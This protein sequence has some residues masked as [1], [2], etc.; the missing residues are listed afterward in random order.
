MSKEHVEKIRT[1]GETPFEKY[2]DRRKAGKVADQATADAAVGQLAMPPMDPT[3]GAKPVPL[4]PKAATSLSGLPPITGPALEAQQA[5]RSADIAQSKSQVDVAELQ[6][7]LAKVTKGELTSE[8]LVTRLAA[9]YGKLPTGEELAV[10][11]GDITGKTTAAATPG[12]LAYKQTEARKI[13]DAQVDKSK[14]TDPSDLAR[15]QNYSQYLVGLTDVVPEKLPERLSQTQLKMEEKAQELREKMF[16]FDKVKYVA[17]TRNMT[18]QAGNALVNSGVDPQ[19]AFK[20]ADEYLKTGKLPEGLVLAPDKEQ[21]L[22]LDVAGLQAQKLQ[23][24]IEKLRADDPQVDLILKTL[25]QYPTSRTAMEGHTKYDSPAFQALKAKLAARG[26]TLPN[27]IPPTLFDKFLGAATFGMYTPQSS[28]VGEVKFTQPG[29]VP[30]GAPTGAPAPGAGA[31]TPI[32]T[33]EIDS[34]FTKSVQ[35]AAAL[36]PQLDPAGKAQMQEKLK[37]L[38]T[39]S[40]SK[41]PVAAAKAISELTQLMALLGKK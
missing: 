9:R 4:V 29:A 13:F 31:A 30:E 21:Q 10:V 27:T 11:G 6:G 40:G 36:M 8:D 1:T 14:I 2:M 37:A 22:K 20:F 17:D 25:Q 15:L 23:L 38:Q 33:P 41:D 35:D 7:M 16:N 32:W 28:E 26:V 24:E 18:M 5:R 12:T 3:A 34:A 39:A 19:L